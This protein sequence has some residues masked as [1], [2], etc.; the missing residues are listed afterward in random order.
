[1]TSEAKEHPGFAIVHVQSPCI[2][3]GDQLRV[4]VTID[5]ELFEEAQDLTGIENR[6]EVV[7]AGIRAL[8]ERESARRLAKL[9]GAM[10]DLKP[11]PRRRI[12]PAPDKTDKHPLSGIGGT[13]PDLEYVPRRRSEPA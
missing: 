12:E 5:D 2:E 11:I 8:I 13:Q 4:T 7:R 3:W 1:M 6:A 9:G 10:P